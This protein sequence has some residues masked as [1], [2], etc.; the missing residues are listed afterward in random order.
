MIKRS[1]FVLKRSDKVSR[2]SKRFSS[3]T[4]FATLVIACAVSGWALGA[5]A[6]NDDEYN[7]VCRAGPGMQFHLT[8]TK[9]GEFHT[10]DIQIGKAERGFEVD[11]AGLE[12]GQ[13]AWLDR[14]ITREEPWM[15]RF[16]II[17]NFDTDDRLSDGSPRFS[18][19]ERRFRET[20]AT[21]YAS[22][23]IGRAEDGLVLS[24]SEPDLDSETRPY[25]RLEEFKFLD[26]SFFT[27][28]AKVGKPVP[29]EGFGWKIKAPVFVV[30]S[31]RQGGI[32][33]DGT[34]LQV[35]PR[36]EVYIAR[37]SAV[38]TQTTRR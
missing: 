1:Y 20:R 34:V 30:S 9:R 10:L 2:R 35:N 25:K 22:V 7:M 5:N 3:L 21:R 11:P 6:Q 16:W 8:P 26:G 23:T 27:L 15:A 4:K 33:N 12:P 13:C 19:F 24:V 28:S 37:T 38:Q 31:I 36:G 17:N 18:I 14:A 29:R 32:L